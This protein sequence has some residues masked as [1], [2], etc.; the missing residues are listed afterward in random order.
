MNKSKL[1]KKKGHLNP[2]TAVN[3]FNAL[4]QISYYKGTIVCLLVYNLG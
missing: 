2:T 4:L 1:K 3:S